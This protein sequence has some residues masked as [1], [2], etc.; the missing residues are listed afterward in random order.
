VDAGAR[1]LSSVSCGF[2][3]DLKSKIQVLLKP[4]LM[5]GGGQ[6]KFEREQVRGE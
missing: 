5:V 2:P 1:Y 6:K 3:I 4:R